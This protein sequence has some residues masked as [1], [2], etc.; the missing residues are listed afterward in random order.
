MT[1]NPALHVIPHRL[2]TWFVQREGDHEPLSEHSSETAAEEA[3]ARH[4]GDAEVIV[5]DRYARL[6]VAPHSET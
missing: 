4:A 3:A 5:H 1:S 2:G 6:H